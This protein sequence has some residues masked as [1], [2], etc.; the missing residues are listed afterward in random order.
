M[1]ASFLRRSARA[2]IIPV[3]AVVTALIIG[4]IIMYI[5]GDDPIKAYKGLLT[6]AFGWG[7]PL[8]GTARRMSPL[9]LTGLSVAIAF[10]A[11]LF[12]IGA[13]GQYIMGTLA[14]V[15]VAT[16]FE[17]LSSFVHLPLALIAGI[18]GGMVW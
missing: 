2:L 14:S 11:G 16:H 4:A 1:I 15:A 17:G 13:A 6:G 12:N 7:R 10:K 3:L 18:A 8:A 5:F 9:I